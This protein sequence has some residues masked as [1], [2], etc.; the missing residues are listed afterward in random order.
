MPAFSKKAIFLYNLVQDFSTK[1]IYTDFSALYE[2]KGSL[3]RSCKHSFFGDDSS[4]AAT[5]PL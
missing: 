2:G 1:I 5:Q 4:V 3:W